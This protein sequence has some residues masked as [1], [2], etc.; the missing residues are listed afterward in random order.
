MALMRGATLLRSIV[1]N[2]FATNFLLYLDVVRTQWGVTVLQLPNPTA[3]D[4]YDP[5]LADEYP[6]IGMYII[7][8]ADYTRVDYSPLMEEEFEITYSCRMFCAVETPKDSEG[9]WEQPTH[10]SATRLREDLI[11]AMRAFLLSQTSLGSPAVV[12]QEDTINTDYPE[13]MKPRTQGDRYIGSGI[14]AAQI[15]FTE[16]LYRTQIGTADT[17]VVEPVVLEDE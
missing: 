10:K 2:H 9:K 14:I 8:D 5:F 1:A 6:I 12:L 7:S 11:T 13:M 17:I 3:F 15:K 16:S 4:A